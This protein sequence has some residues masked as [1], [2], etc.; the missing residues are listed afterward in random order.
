MLGASHTARIVFSLTH[1]CFFQKRNW[2]SNFSLVITVMFSV[3]S[4]VECVTG[5]LIKLSDLPE[6]VL[7]VLCPSTCARATRETRHKNDTSA[8]GMHRGAV[9]PCS[10]LQ[11]PW[12]LRPLEEAL[13]TRGSLNMSCAS[14]VRYDRDG[15][16]MPIIEGVDAKR[17][18][19]LP[20]EVTCQRSTEDFY[21]KKRQ[22]FSGPHHIKGTRKEVVPLMITTRD[23][24]SQVSYNSINCLQ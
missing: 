24:P 23:L 11:P 4:L 18:S 6:V 2:E 21:H 5:N 14:T 17:E 13:L 22:F 1:T 19:V 8:M 16:R 7:R 10:K 12:H 20:H 3:T 15:L 9:Q